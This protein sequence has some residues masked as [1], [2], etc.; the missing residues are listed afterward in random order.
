MSINKIT[1][2]FTGIYRHNDKSIPSLYTEIM[3][4]ESPYEA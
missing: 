1:R 3:A 2:Q 4:K